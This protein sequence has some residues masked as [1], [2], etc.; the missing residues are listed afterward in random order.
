AFTKFDNMKDNKEF[1]VIIIGGSYAG[2]SAAM[3][4]GRSRRNVRIIERGR[5][6]TRY[7]PHPHKVSSHD[8]AVPGAMA[9]K[10]REPA[11]TFDTAKF[12][13][14]LGVDGR[15]TEIGFEIAIDSG[16]KFSSKKLVFATGV[17]DVFPDIKGFQDCWGK[18]VIHCPYCHG[19]EFKGE[20]TVVL[21]NGE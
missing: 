16:E 14:G 1:D 5:P 11:L 3:A 2:L 18:T 15:K 21:A 20:K 9:G 12:F 7:R 4:L 13:E 10:A 17:K 19:Y 8:G 6:R